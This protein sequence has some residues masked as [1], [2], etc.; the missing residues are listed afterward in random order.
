[1]KA[2]MLVAEFWL[3]FEETGGEA[4][5]RELLTR[6]GVDLMMQILEPHLSDGEPPGLSGTAAPARDGGG[7]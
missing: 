3:P 1:A 4:S 5:G 7:R 6:E 2:L